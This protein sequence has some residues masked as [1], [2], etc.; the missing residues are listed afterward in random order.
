MRIKHVLSMALLGT[1][2]LLLAGPGLAAPPVQTP[3]PPDE[4]PGAP[5]AAAE[6]Y[7]FDL[8]EVI[9][10]SALTAAPQGGIIEIAT[11]D[12]F[13]ESQAAVALCASDQYLVVYQSAGEIYGQRLES[14]GDLLGDAF[15]IAEGPQAKSDP[16]VACDWLYNRFVV[17][18]EYDFYG[19]GSDY[20]VRARGVYGGHQASGSQLYGIELAVSETNSGVWEW[21]PAIACNS[22]DHTCLVAFAYSGTGGGDIYG[23]RVSVGGSSIGK[24]GARFTISGYGARESNPDVAWGGY[25]DD[26]LVVWQY[27]HETPSPH[28]RVFAGYVW[29]TNQAGSQVQTAGT[30]LIAPGSHDHDQIVPAAAYNPRTRQYLVVFE[31]DYFGNGTDR[32]IEALRLTPGGGSWGGV[33]SVAATDRDEQCPAV[34]FSGGTQSFSGGKGADQFLVTYR[35]EVDSTDAFYAQA[36]K[37]TYATSGSQREGAPVHMR[38]TE[39]WWHQWVDVVGSI[40]NGRYVVV[41]NECTGG[42]LDCDVLGQMVAPYGVYLPVMLDRP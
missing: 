1:A 17:V 38:T 24:E 7:P 27:W 28:D 22:F 35:R 2:L 18:W 6:A 34:A 32:D 4:A 39:Q 12:G 23:Q 15:Q 41:W 16:D 9:S 42:D 10:R 5:G 40:N 21:D 20:D 14:D 26:Y 25:D 11:D 3:E 36:V 8:K 33:F 37:G 29:D 19:N 13:D 30:Y 31:Y